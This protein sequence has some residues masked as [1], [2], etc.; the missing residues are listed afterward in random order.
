MRETYENAAAVLVLDAW[1]TS[2]AIADLSPDEVL[3]RIFQ[4]TWNRRLWTYQEGALAKLLFFQFKDGVV[5]IDSY[6]SLRNFKKQNGGHADILRHITPTL[7]TRTTSV[8][9]DESLCLATL[10]DLD[11]H[12]LMQTPPMSRLECVWGM[13]D[14]VPSDILLGGHDTLDKSGLRWAPKSLLT[15]PSNFNHVGRY[16]PIQMQNIEEIPLARVTPSGLR[17]RQSGIVFNVRQG[18][19]GSAFMLKDNK[20][21]HHFFHVHFRKDRKYTEYGSCN[22]NGQV[23]HIPI[24]NIL[25]TYGTSNIAF[26]SM[27]AYSPT[28]AGTAVWP[29]QVGLLVAIHRQEEGTFY[30]RKIT[31]ALRELKGSASQL[32]DTSILDKVYPETDRLAKFQDIPILGGQGLILHGVS[33]VRKPVTQAWCIE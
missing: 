31:T 24:M 7:G 26:V 5:E 10:L 16:S 19:L 12:R 8:A 29:S 9:E 27:T 20:G 2:C 25:G 21:A 1:L 11:M 4:T 23:Q 6:W 32:I 28:E 14:V 30:G 33:G 17:F 15:T 22:I 18:R 13:V 3:M